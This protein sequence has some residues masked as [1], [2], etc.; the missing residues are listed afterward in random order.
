MKN[1]NFYPASILKSGDL[2]TNL[3]Q[4][5]SMTHEGDGAEI[6]KKVQQKSTQSN[7]IVPR[8][9]AQSCPICWQGNVPRRWSIGLCDQS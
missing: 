2:I 1:D 4:N 3:I 8:D 7:V 5:I 6:F 9:P